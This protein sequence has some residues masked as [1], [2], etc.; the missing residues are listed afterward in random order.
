MKKYFLVLLSSS[1]LSTVLNGCSGILP[2]E[3]SQEENLSTSEW[4]TSESKLSKTEETSSIEEK[5]TDNGKVDNSCSYYGTW[6]IRDYQSTGISALSSDD[7]E[8]FQG[9]TITYQSDSILLDDENVTV[10]Y[11][12]DETDNFVYDYDS[13]TD[14]YNVNLG[15]WW[16]NISEVTYITIDS[17]KS[18]FGD[19]FF[20]V[21]SDTIWIYYEGAFFLAKKVNF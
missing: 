2:N 12:T 3:N 8:S 20:V 18:F 19:Q 14:A 11:F 15:E 17:N 10:D 16:D 13:L 5:P 6:E 21:D 1:I 7:M 4:E 9:I